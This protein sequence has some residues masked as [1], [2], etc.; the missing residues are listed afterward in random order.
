MFDQRMKENDTT[1]SRDSDIRGDIS[2][3]MTHIA[4]QFWNHFESD[5]I[6]EDFFS[7]Y[8]RTR[9]TDSRK[10]SVRCS[11]HYVSSSF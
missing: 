7:K 1:W 2:A 6:V 11:M 9:I 5:L 8:L 3:V 10:S 4:A